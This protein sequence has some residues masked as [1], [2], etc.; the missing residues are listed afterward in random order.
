MKLHLTP[1]PSPKIGEG[2]S[3]VDIARGCLYGL[4][5]AALFWF[6]VIAIVCVV[7]K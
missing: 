7:L 4:G 3:G 2:S 6:T 1:S 5:F